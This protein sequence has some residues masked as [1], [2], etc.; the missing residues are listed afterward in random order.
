ME[1]PRDNKSII[2][3]S[4][5][6]ETGNVNSQHIMLMVDKGIKKNLRIVTTSEGR[7]ARRIY[8]RLKVVRII[9]FLV[10]AIQSFVEK[11]AWCLNDDSLRD[12]STCLREEASRNH[13]TSGVT[14]LDYSLSRFISLGL[15]FVLNFFEIL[16][17]I[18]RVQTKSF[19]LKHNILIAVS[20]ISTIEIGFI[21]I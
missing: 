10:L 5:L 7:L 15:L 17:G 16:K 8:L 4:S 19:K 13:L 11:P 1:R 2:N 18:Y 12:T 3:T 6:I 20:L 21:F 9:A 14:Y